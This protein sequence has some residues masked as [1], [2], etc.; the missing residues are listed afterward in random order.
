MSTCTVCALASMI[1]QTPPAALNVG[2][3]DKAPFFF[4]PPTRFRISLKNCLGYVNKV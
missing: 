1:N 4:I 3:R 2:G